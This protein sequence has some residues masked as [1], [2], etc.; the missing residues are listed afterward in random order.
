MNVTVCQVLTTSVAG[1]GEKEMNNLE[2]AKY[3]SGIMEKPLK[4]KLVN[5]H[6][7]RPGHDLRYSLNGDKLIEM[8]WK[9]PLSFYDSLKRTVKWTL[10]NRKWLE[11]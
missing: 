3:I 6:K 11:W 9:L 10:E 8:G 1:R 5:C 7:D 4:Y 2:I